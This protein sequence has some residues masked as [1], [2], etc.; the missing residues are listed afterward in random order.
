MQLTVRQ[1]A[2]L[3]GVT[4][5]TVARWIRDDN[6]PVHDLKS[7]Y[8]FDRA[9]L[10]EWAAT[11]HRRFSPAIFDEIN[12][13]CVAE[14]RLA[15]AIERGGLAACVAGGDRYEVFR[16]AIADWPLPE[17]CSRHELLDLF[18]AREKSG[19]TAI[20]YGIAV[21]H[22][23]YPVVLPG[24]PS[25]MRVCFLER[26]LP[27]GGRDGQPVDA[28]FLTISPTVHEHLQL[29]A[30]LA[31]VVKSDAFRS[32]LKSRPDHGRIVEEVRRVEQAFH[33]H[34]DEHRELSCG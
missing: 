24:S 15:D 17:P 13:D 2:D 6:L 12:G 26:P 9:E 16:A 10:L 30:R 18:L 5:S 7:Q 32:F 34:R 27:M 3:F 8:R 28:L 19:G 11:T 1:V 23:R 4:E 21:P 25:M 14:V 22:P 20:G 31:C 33:E 29:L